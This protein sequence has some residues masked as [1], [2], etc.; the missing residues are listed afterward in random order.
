MPKL[1]SFT[2]LV[3]NE[4][5]NLGGNFQFD[6][7]VKTNTVEEVLQNIYEIFSV[8]IYSQPYLRPFGNDVSWIDAPGNIA[9]LQMQVAF[10][11]ACA[12]WE[13]RAKFNKIQFSIPNQTGLFATMD[14]NTYVAGI[15]A[16]YTELE[17]DLSIQIKN[18]LFSGPTPSQ[19][20]IVDN[21]MTGV[22]PTVQDETLTL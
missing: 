14:A 3:G 16:L 10:L 18:N 22:Y 12:K 8:P 6:F 21:P 13:P 19:S 7:S 9:Q 20:W 5:W 1:S 2:A 17:I 11:L 4:L 15:Y